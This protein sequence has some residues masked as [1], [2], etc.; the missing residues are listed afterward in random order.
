MT[1]PPGKLPHD[2]L[3]RLLSKHTR[4]TDPRLRVG[5]GIGEDAAVIDFGPSP[6]GDSICLVAKT[7]PI[8]FATEQIGWY[9]V[10]VNANDIAAMGATPRWF[11]STV[12]VPQHMATDTLFED[13]LGQID[14]AC[15][16][17]NV[18][19]AGGHT[20][21]TTGID[22]P[23]VVGQMLGEVSSGRV[24][25]S[26][27]LLPGDAILLTKGLAIEATSIV[28]QEMASHLQ[29][30]GWSDQDLAAAAAYLTD[31]GISVVA[32][33]RIA[34]QAGDVHAL[35]DPTE[36][37]VATALL[38]IATASGVGL[39]I[40]AAH[41]PTSALTQRLCD[42]VGI[43]P[44]GAISSGA[45]LIG[46]DDSC[47]EEILDAL[48]DD[49]IDAARIGTA[50]RLGSDQADLRSVNLKPPGSVEHQPDGVP[51]AAPDPSNV[52]PSGGS[53]RLRLDGAWQPLPHFRV[54]EIARLFAHSS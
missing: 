51:S 24:V 52:G 33:A 29:D 4:R 38:E 20:E 35:H 42:D 9:A 17:L 11:L 14:A 54:D 49:G 43:D 44:F 16:S 12:I 39:D 31:P 53:L 50:T 34:L 13:I 1:Y 40:E 10:H 32:D 45:L 7:D 19:V 30:R 3:A 48:R 47:A 8:T 41:L 26:S 23:L 18:S 5:P 46:C 25:R 6:T 37:G 27:G 15:A 28:A 2:V 36:G 21:I 22:R